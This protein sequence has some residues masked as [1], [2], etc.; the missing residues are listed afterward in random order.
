MEL[1]KELDDDDEENK[2]KK[3]MANATVG[4]RKEKKNR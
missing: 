3:M 2:R 1:D 4:A